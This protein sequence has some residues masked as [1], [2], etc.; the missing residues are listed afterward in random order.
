MQ[1]A[2]RPASGKTA[3]VFRPLTPGPHV[4]RTAVIAFPITLFVVWCLYIVGRSGAGQ[5][6]KWDRVPDHIYFSVA[7]AGT[8]YLIFVAIALIVL[9]FQR[10]RGGPDSA[11]SILVPAVIR[12]AVVFVAAVVIASPLGELFVLADE[13][14]FR[15]ET[16]KFLSTAKPVPETGDL[17]LYSRMRRWPSWSN[18]MVSPDVAPPER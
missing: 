2:G 16:A 3:H 4:N 8:L 12:F 7:F 15:K 17:P 18:V 9:Y 1:I 5:G 13:R 11:I 10:I 14:A 6:L